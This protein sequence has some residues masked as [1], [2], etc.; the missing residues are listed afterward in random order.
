MKAAHP[1]DHPFQLPREFHTDLMSPSL[2]SALKQP[3]G[4]YG[5]PVGI[6]ITNYHNDQLNVLCT[7][8]C[9]SMRAGT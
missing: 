9:I 7:P 1:M 8:P 2:L 3:R 6:I 4:P 5:T